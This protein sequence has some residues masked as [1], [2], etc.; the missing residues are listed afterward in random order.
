MATPVVAA[1]ASIVR[2]WFRDGFYPTLVRTAANA[3]SPSGTS[4]E[5][6][7]RMPIVPEDTAHPTKAGGRSRRPLK[8][9][10]GFRRKQEA[11][12]CPPLVMDL[13]SL[14]PH[15]SLR[16]SGQGCIAGRGNPDGRKC[17]FVGSSQP[18]VESCTHRGDALLQ[19][20]AVGGPILLVEAS[21][22]GNMGVR[23]ALRSTHQPLSR[24]RLS[25]F[26]NFTYV[27]V[28]SL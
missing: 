1:S 22:K 18:A 5:R 7:G 13:T 17:A 24:V 2:Q 4:E 20:E 11:Y 8:E 9:S 16:C 15:P 21:N 28:S 6:K 12:R 19:V 14:F 3:Y 27:P 10:E 26:C 25:I 23:E